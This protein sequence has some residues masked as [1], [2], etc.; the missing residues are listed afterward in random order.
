MSIAAVKH[1]YRWY[2]F[3]PTCGLCSFTFCLLFYQYVHVFFCNV[4]VEFGGICPKIVAKGKHLI[5]RLLALKLR[6]H[7]L[8]VTTGFSCAQCLHNYPDAKTD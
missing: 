1:T 8:Y 6:M 5:L 7:K 2:N 3:N 4:V